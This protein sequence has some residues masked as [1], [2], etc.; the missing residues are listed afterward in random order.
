MSCRDEAAI[1]LRSSGKRVTSARIAVIEALRHSAAHMTPSMVAEVVR[2]EVP[3][4]DQSTVYRTL[5]ELRD[6]GLIAET[7]LGQGEFFFEWL[8]GQAHHHLRCVSCGVLA[9]LD[10]SLV[11][12]LADGARKHQGFSLDTSHVILEGQCAMCQK[13][14][15]TGKN[16]RQAT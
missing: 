15:S 11:E 12:G 2:K 14:A 8:D 4:V 9:A 5:A 6:T 3:H 10:H 16:E 1:V 7:R 13:V